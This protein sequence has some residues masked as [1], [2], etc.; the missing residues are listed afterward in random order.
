MG[1]QGRRQNQPAADI[2]AGIHAKAILGIGDLAGQFGFAFQPGA[3]V[4]RDTPAHLADQHIQYRIRTQHAGNA[5]AGW[6]H[7]FGAHA[8]AEIGVV[9]KR[10][11]LHRRLMPVSTPGPT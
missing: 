11:K 10:I 9:F 8:E 6:N 1:M 5:T 4:H 3:G 7:R 2:T